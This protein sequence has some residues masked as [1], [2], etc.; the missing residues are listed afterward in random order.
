MRGEPVLVTGGAG[1]IGSHLVDAL[2]AAGAETRVL[3][4][5]T[6]G[7]T[8]NL[9]TSRDRIE[10]VRGDVRDLETC[11]AACAGR[12]FV[13]HLA[14]LSSVPRSIDD[15]AAFLA[16]NVMG[17][18]HV[19]V[20]AREAGV[21]RTVY[22]SSSSVYGDDE[23]APKREGR[24]GT[25]LSPYAAS[26][27]ACEDLAALFHRCYGQDLVG[28]RFFNVFG[29]R[30]DPEGDYAA[31]IP[32][33]FQACLAGKAPTIYGDG[34]QS[35]DFITAADAARAA[36]LAATAPARAAGRAFNVAGGRQTTVAELADRIRELTGSVAEPVHADPRPGDVLHSYADGSQA[37][38]VLGYEPSQTLGEGLALA[39]DYYRG[40]FAPEVLEGN[41]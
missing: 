36:L 26:K 14:A 35:R 19:F 12:R 4:N 23:E 1:F 33:F 22:A 11:R 5:F 18:T 32:R 9:R 6:S 31:V 38:E 17:S 27:R 15:P 3:D 2:V 8:E 39:L 40:R 28:L 34:S 7:T 16:T 29:S 13:F 10:I 25:L 30:Q 20:A 21:E 41:E 24:E 37:A